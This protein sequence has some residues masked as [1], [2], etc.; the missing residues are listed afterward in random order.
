MA[1]VVGGG[2]GKGGTA[3][4][5]A[6]IMHPSHRGRPILIAAL[7][8]CSLAVEWALREG[9]C[10]GPSSSLCGG[11]GL[12]RT[13]LA[14]D[15]LPRFRVQASHLESWRIVPAAGSSASRALDT[16]PHA[17]A[18]LAHASPATV[19]RASFREGR[20]GGPG[21]IRPRRRRGGEGEGRQRLTRG[22]SQALYGYRQC[23]VHD[24]QLSKAIAFLLAP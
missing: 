16:A 11:N 19:R 21:A 1:C 24:G 13:G 15:G 5:W 10:G 9:A 20:A 6:V 7:A 12:G 14:W 17:T 8:V 22:E 3:R 2:E 18:R 23:G 4:Q